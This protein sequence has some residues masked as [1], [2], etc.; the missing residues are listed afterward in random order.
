VQVA[1][2]TPRERRSSHAFRHYPRRPGRT[3]QNDRDIQEYTDPENALVLTPGL[4]IHSVYNG[5]WFWGSP[6]ARPPPA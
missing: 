5:Y 1:C 4:V 2:A 6:V 3:I